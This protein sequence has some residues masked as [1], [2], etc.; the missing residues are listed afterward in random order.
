MGHELDRAIATLAARQHGVV[1]RT[2]LLALGVG[3]GAVELRLRRGRLHRWQPGVYSVGHS[4]LSPEGHA[5]AAVLA[6]GPGAVLSHRAAAEL[7]RIR[8]SARR[9]IEVT[10]G[11]R[12]QAGP[13]VQVHRGSLPADEV[14]TR[15]R[16]PVTTVPRTLVDLAGVLT[17]RQL[18]R[19]VREAEFL[20]L[21]DAL[22][23]ETV[24]DRH[25][26]CR[27]APALRAILAAGRAGD[28]MTRS[29]LEELF[30]VVIDQAGLPR[31]SLNAHVAVADGSIECDCVWRAQRLVVELDSHRAHGRRSAFEGDRARDRA[32]S[33]A[34]WRVVR[35][36]SR[37]LERDRPEIV[38]DLRTMLAR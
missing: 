12:R 37:Q 31:P 29:E 23:I 19:A 16:I 6:A 21:W 15:N 38:A 1:A 3:R 18:E 4:L 25:R 20:R 9:R 13:R 11:T 28:G 8:A 33:L 26:G 10:V 34:G 36:T 30:L 7:W 32:L 24:L 35:V 27:G 5:M 14:T 22:S 2:Q 17:P